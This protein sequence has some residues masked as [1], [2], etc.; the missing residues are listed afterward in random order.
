MYHGEQS[1][2]VATHIQQV[3]LYQL[4]FNKNQSQNET[5]KKNKRH[6]HTQRTAVNKQQRKKY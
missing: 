3:S 6:T 1:Q 2:L 4:V 5:Q